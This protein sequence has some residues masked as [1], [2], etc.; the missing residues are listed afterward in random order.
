MF[1][2]STDLVAVGNL[3]LPLIHHQRTITYLWE[4]LRFDFSRY[5][6]VN[7]LVEEGMVFV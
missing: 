7:V 5:I 3:V 2:N 4:Y 1:S 6:N